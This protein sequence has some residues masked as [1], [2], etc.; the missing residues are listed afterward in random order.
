MIVIPP[1]DYTAPGVLVAGAADE[2][3]WAAGTT[4][5]L[6]DI[7]SKNRVK[8]QS[9]QA[10]NT[11]HDPE[12]EPLWWLP[13]GVSNQWA[14]F[15]NAVQT[16]STATNTL[17]VTLKTGRVSAV[18]LLGLVGQSVTITVRD[19]LGGP[20]LFTNTKTLLASDGSY[21]SYVFDRP[22]QVFEAIWTNL[23]SSG[24]GHI[25][26]TITGAGTVACGLCVVGRQ[27]FIGQAQYG[28]SL[29][30][31]E[32]GR[33]YLDA[34]GNPVIVDRG[35]AKGSSGTVVSSRAEFNRLN[36]FYRENLSTP[37]LWVAAPDMADLT[38]ATVFGKLARVVV[39]IAS[40]DEITSSIEISGYR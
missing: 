17:T 32:R 36:N 22:Q 1:I 38:S 28:V 18:G 10:P 4:Y 6:N 24:N 29:N 34:L 11:G 23:P 2:P 19:G 16:A 33:S 12:T 39:A 9:I 21:Y 13:K 7:V 30:L 14:M 3:A 35:T 8:Y 40:Y 26:I 27:F 5:A 20:V 31:E 37:C 15:D 25:T